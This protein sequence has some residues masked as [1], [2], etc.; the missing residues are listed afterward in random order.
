MKT[1]YNKGDHH[2]IVVLIQILNH[3]IQAKTITLG[4]N[5]NSNILIN[6][7][8]NVLLNQNSKSIYKINNYNWISYKK[9]LLQNQKNKSS[10]LLNNK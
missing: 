9:Q 1:G 6:K 2:K 7:L 5:I 4:Q 8:N 10:N 3:Q